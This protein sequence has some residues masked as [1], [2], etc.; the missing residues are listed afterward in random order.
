[1]KIWGHRGAS[2]Y[3]PENTMKAYRLAYEQGADGIEIDVHLSKDGIPV[4]MHDETLNRTSN[5]SGRIVDYPLSVLKQADVGEGE[6][7][8]TL[9]EVLAFIAD[10]RMEINIEVKSDIILYPGLERKVTDMVAEFG[11]SDLVYYSSFNHYCLLTL[12]KIVP[13]A[14]VGL[15]YMAGLVEP[16]DYALKLG[17]DAL[18]PYLPCLQLDDYIANAHRHHLAVRP[19]TVNNQNDMFELKKAGVDAIITNDVKLARRISDD[20]AG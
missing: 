15:L 7:I 5:L 4:I 18:H 3:A 16:W 19:W 12:K 10:T 2:A 8:P 11:V 13:E 9:R 6:K 17:A 1:M 20:A 14:R